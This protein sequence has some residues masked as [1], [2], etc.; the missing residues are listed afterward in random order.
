MFGTFDFDEIAEAS[1]PSQKQRRV[2]RA[3]GMDVEKRPI[4]T[5]ASGTSKTGSTKVESVLKIIKDVREYIGIYSFS[6]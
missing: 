5:T 1:Q 4:S 6:F 3:N 2:R